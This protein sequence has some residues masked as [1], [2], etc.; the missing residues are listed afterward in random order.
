[1]I[2]ATA[3]RLR[4][5]GDETN[6]AGLELLSTEM[7]DRIDYQLRLAH[8][9]I[10]SDAQSFASSLDDAL[11]RSVAVIR[12]TGR[13]SEL[14]WNLSADRVSG[15]IDSHDLMELVGVLLENAA[16]WA[17]SEV[18]VSCRLANGR[19]QFVVSDD[20]PGIPD[21]QRE[22]LG[23]R[24]HRLDETKP[25]T[26]IGLAVAKEIV[27]LNSGTLLLATSAKGGLSAVVDLPLAP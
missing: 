9:R 18:Q 8:L 6:A 3:D 24:G 1:V 11:I 19:A 10:R 23:V 26:G 5:K 15:N 16:K 21:Q 4:F 7:G 2:K 20:G 27:R 25:G 14:Y 17:R 22:N 13:G 12:K